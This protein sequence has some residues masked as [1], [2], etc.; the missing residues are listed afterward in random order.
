MG[1]AGAVGYMAVQM[2]SLAGADV[3][4]VVRSSDNAALV[5]E[6]GARACVDLS[7]TTTQDVVDHYTKGMGF[8][9]IF[10]TVGGEMLDAAFKMIKPCS[11]VVTVVGTASHNVAPAYLKGVNLHMVLV[12][13]PIMF[14]IEKEKQGRILVRIAQMVE[15]GQLKSRVDPHHFA[16]SETADARRKYESGSAAGKIVIDVAR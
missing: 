2:A 15:N 13:T 14:G 16:L 6:A 5:L 3:V 9:V 11:D 1:G 8:D 12:L 7:Q 10:D 4:A